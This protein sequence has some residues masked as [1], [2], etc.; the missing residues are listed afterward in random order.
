MPELGRRWSDVSGVAHMGQ[1]SPRTNQAQPAADDWSGWIR[2]APP[3]DMPTPHRRLDLGA[4]TSRVAELREA[5]LVAGTVTLA[6]SV[7]TCPQPELLAAA[8]ALGLAPEVISMDELDAAV[9]HG[10]LAN[11]AI[12][13]GPAKWWPT[14]SSVTCRAFFADSVAELRALRRRLDEGFVLNTEVVGVRVRSPGEQSRFG[15]RLEVDE[16]NEVATLVGDL[17]ERL[18]AGWGIHFHHASSTIGLA[19]WERE[20]VA[21]LARAEGIGARLG[22]P[23]TL[24]DMGGGWDHDDLAVAAAACA[25]IVRWWTNRSDETSEF[26]IEPG[27]LLTQ[28]CAT[29]VTRVIAATVIEDESCIIVDASLGDL[30]EGPHRWHPVARYRNGWESLPPGNGRL[31]GRSCMETDVLANDLNLNGLKEGD[32]IAIGMAGAYDFSMSYDFG[33][34][35]SGQG[36]GT[37]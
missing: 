22:R 27:K 33:R 37:A 16:L 30:P 5:L 36:M 6:Y 7:K 9:T 4:F 29:V 12:L 23:P 14:R 10:M 25:R 26:V 31:L 8:A 28:S 20:A 11:R 17:V 21:A 24:V 32:F 19:R 35:F 1:V 34:G 18:G 15:I 3:A 13:N 2:V